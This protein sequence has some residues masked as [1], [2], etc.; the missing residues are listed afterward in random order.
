MLVAFT[1]S[2]RGLKLSQSALLIE[3]EFNI[4]AILAS[5]EIILM[6]SGS[7]LYFH[8]LWWLLSD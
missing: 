4:G 5:W 8:V 1:Y 7:I 3:A 6:L 2:E